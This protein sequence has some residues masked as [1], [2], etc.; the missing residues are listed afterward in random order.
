M[1]NKLQI[2]E[3]WLALCFLSETIFFFSAAYSENSQQIWQIFLIFLS[4]EG[5]SY[6][7]TAYIYRTEHML[8]LNYC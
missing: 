1:K 3:K 6:S 8:G 4:S 5:L 7:Y 2:K